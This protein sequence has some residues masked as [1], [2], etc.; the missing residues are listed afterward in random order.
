M[1]SVL[2]CF[3]LIGQIPAYA[4]RR[5]ARL[6][7]TRWLETNEAKS[8]ESR[9]GFPIY[10]LGSKD[11]LFVIVAPGNAVRARGELGRLGVSR[12]GQGAAE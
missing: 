6:P 9:N 4:E 3:V 8:F 7:V 1:I 11:G 5:V 10:Q 2:V 12:S